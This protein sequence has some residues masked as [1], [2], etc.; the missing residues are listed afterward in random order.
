MF[1]NICFENS[2]SMSNVFGKTNFQTGSD[3]NNTKTTGGFLL[4]KKLKYF[5]QIV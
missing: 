1:Q 3:E 2:V 5:P 4:A